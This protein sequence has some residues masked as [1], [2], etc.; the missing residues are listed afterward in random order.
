VSKTIAEK[1][2]SAK[3]GNDVQAGEIVEAKVD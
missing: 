1:V 2:L 3:S